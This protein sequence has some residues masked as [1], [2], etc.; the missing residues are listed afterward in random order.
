MENKKT[1]KKLQLNKEVIAQLKDNDLSSIN[2]G[3][4]ETFNCGPTQ[5]PTIV[6]CTENLNCWTTDT[7]TNPTLTLISVDPDII[8]QG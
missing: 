7:T 4:Y 3:T 2:G 6:E 5:E 8:C 1:T